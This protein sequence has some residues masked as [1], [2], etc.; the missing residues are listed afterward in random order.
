MKTGTETG[1]KQPQA[2]E[3]PP[4]PEAGRHGEPLSSRAPVG[5]IT[6]LTP[7]VGTLGLQSRENRLLLL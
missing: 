4:P 3:P 5:D 2:K 6:L 1:A 7:C